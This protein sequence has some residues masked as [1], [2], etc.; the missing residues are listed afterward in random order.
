MSEENQ[1]QNRTDVASDENELHFEKTS[2]NWR[3][4]LISSGFYGLLIVGVFISMIVA[5]VYAVNDKDK[6][7]RFHAVQALLLNV[8]IQIPLMIFG[9]I[10]TYG[11]EAPSL[12][13]QYT[14]E[15]ITFLSYSNLA[16][17]FF[18]MYKATVNYEKQA[19]F[20]LPLIGSWSYKMVA[21]K[22]NGLAKSSY[23]CKS[24]NKEIEENAAY[25]PNCGA[26]NKP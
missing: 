21:S 16:L 12:F 8:F 9:S 3:P 15:I 1:T 17:I 13:G 22:K 7:I 4:K 19:Y 14:A 2:S 24:C 20:K 5:V 26:P 25:C 6:Y 11:L 18:M 23:N 10:L